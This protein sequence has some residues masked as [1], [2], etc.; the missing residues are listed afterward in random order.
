MCGRFT[1]RTP[2]EKFAELFS[3][4][5]AID[6]APRYNIAPSQQVAAI[7]ADAHGEWELT[8]LRWGLVPAWATDAKIGNRMIN[9]RAE[10]VH[11]KPAFRSAFKSRRCLIPADGFYE[12][13]QQGTEKLPVY[14]HRKSDEPFFF[15]GLWEHNERLPLAS[16]TCTIITTAA[17]RDL[18][19][20]HPRMPVIL[21][22]ADWGMWLDKDYADQQ[23]LRG[24]LQPHPDH[25][26]VHFPVSKQVNSPRHD[27]AELIRPATGDEPFADEQASESESQPNSAERQTR[28]FD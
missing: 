27:H 7:R 19:P 1:L 11:E 16:S 14:I 26:L 15:A 18:A 22:E 13:R 25:D 6:V 24:C 3:G 2:A 23:R 4:L 17:N 20:L 8:D 5:P 12:W 21:P 10:S 28:L 9:A